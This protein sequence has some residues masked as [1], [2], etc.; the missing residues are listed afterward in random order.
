MAKHAAATRVAGK[1]ARPS[2][3]QLVV[4]LAAGVDPV[5]LR[6]YRGYSPRHPSPLPLHSVLPDDV[7]LATGTTTATVQE[8]GST[9]TRG[10][11][12]QAPDAR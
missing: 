10:Q 9:W 8:T 12:R 11:Q 4:R 1:Q 6:D 2:R 3:Q 5:R 7:P